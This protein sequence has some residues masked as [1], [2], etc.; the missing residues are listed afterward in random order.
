MTTMDE[1]LLRKFGTETQIVGLIYQGM[2]EAAH[3][4]Y[5]IYL[6]GES[7][8]PGITTE[9]HVEDWEEFVRQLDRTEVEAIERAKDGT[10]TKVFIRKSIR[11]IEQNIMWAVYRRDSYACR[12]CGRN[13]CPL[14]VDHLVTWEVGGP[15]TKDN[16]VACCK[17]CNRIRGNTPYAEWL[18]H[19][20]YR[21]V[22][23]NLT[24]VQRAENRAILDTLDSIPLRV[25]KRKR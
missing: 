10:T 4:Q 12:Y 18:A 1:T 17:R 13:D 8:Q 5:L 14:T 19:D 20:H 24:D 9:L 3:V 7:A 2:V 16:L 15:S 21:E 23:R 22:C 25:G 6:P 11:Q